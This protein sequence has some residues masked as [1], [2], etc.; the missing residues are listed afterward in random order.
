MQFQSRTE[1]RDG[2]MLG[3]HF[4]PGLTH[5]TVTRIEFDE[6][7]VADG[8]PQK[9]LMGSG[10]IPSYHRF[11]GDNILEID[12]FLTESGIHSRI[13]R[14]SELITRSLYDMEIV[15]PLLNNVTEASVK[16]PIFSSSGRDTARVRTN[17]I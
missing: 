6:A 14:G 10:N 9:F 15:S 11:I 1:V 7:E 13:R 12:T 3:E 16:M 17:R 4:C 2:E 5:V 8:D